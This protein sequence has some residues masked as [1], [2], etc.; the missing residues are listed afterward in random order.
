MN[1]LS[2]GQ[3]PKTHLAQLHTCT[4]ENGPENKDKDQDLN[5]FH[6]SFFFNPKICLSIDPTKYNPI[7]FTLH[8]CIFYSLL[9][10]VMN[11]RKWKLPGISFCIHG[12]IDKLQGGKKKRQS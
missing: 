5:S 12:Y 4:C 7:Y 11:P 10:I 9:E 3:D 1:V 6:L 2:F 8:C